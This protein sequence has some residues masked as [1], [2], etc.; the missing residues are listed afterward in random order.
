MLSLRRARKLN[1]NCRVCDALIGAKYIHT[2][3]TSSPVF[4]EAMDSAAGGGD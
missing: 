1:N 3:K 2:L 4:K